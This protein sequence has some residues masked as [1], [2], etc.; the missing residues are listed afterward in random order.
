MD[1]KIRVCR[2]GQEQEIS[3]KRIPPVGSYVKIGG[4]PGWLVVSVISPLAGKIDPE[5]LFAG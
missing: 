3:R 2:R 5:S 1:V 4:Q